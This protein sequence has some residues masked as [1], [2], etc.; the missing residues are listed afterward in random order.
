[1]H[2]N[3][4][5]CEEKEATM[6]RTSE[7]KYNRYSAI[8]QEFM[9]PIATE[10]GLASGFVKR[11]SKLS[12]TTF[13]ETLVLGVLNN[14]EATLNELVQISAKLGVDVSEPGLHGRINEQGVALLKGLLD[15]S[16]KQFAAQGSV[17]AEV[18][19][20]FSRVDILDSTQMILPAA[21]APYFAGHNS[22]GTAAS[23]KLQLSVDYLHGR[24]NA[25]QVGAGRSPDQTCDLAAQLATPGSLQLF[26][27]GYAV[28]DRLRRIGEKHAYFL[29]PLK[30]RTNVY[31]HVA[32]SHP[33]DLAAWLT[34]HDQ[35]LVEHG[36][37][38]GEEER[39]P[40]RLV[41]VRL[42]QPKVDAR[43]RQAQ[44]NA[45]KKGRQVTPRHL[46]L[47][48]WQ[49]LMTNVPEHLLAAEALVTLYRVRWQIE[50]FFK[51]CKSQ[52]KLAAVGPWRL[53]RVL[54]HLYA[55]L[56][57]IVL[58]QWLIAPWRFL[59]EGELSP[60]KAFPIVQRQALP[61][62]HALHAGGVGLA[63]ILADMSDD[64]LRYALKTPR[65][66]SPSTFTRIRQLEVAGA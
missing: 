25:L 2:G 54:C 51:L 59:D 34:A 48:A 16:L 53:H 49:L 10:Q 6:H 18:L 33:L 3:L 56:I 17:P 36:L 9:D 43:R 27:M 39:L 60:V 57:G 24:L 38:V 42:P 31:L 66:S 11:R 65:K 26:D 8:I 7:Q 62:L 23:L 64:F 55:R 12:A 15:S 47:L 21:L 37:F 20:Q 5:V 35:D 1:M 52:F 32:D 41:A 30:T 4:T 45:R 19:A 44:H 14:P 40:V 63:D 50:L 29:T 61:I 58:F 13:T 46:D 22:P 28:L